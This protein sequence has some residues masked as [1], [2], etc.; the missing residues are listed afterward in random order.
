MC[1]GHKLEWQLRKG[2]LECVSSSG[3][4]LSVAVLSEELAYNRQLQQFK[5]FIIDRPL[6]PNYK[7]QTVLYTPYS[8][9]TQFIFPNV[10]IR[11]VRL[12]VQCH[13]I[14][15]QVVLYTSHRHVHCM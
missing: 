3:T 7:V 6:D 9:N 4:S 14:T 12:Y 10:L 11:G 13:L 1:N 8:I 15:E 2:R 5:M